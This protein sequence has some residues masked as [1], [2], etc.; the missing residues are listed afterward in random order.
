MFDVNNMNVL[1]TGA[2]RGIGLALAK[3]FKKAGANVWKIG[4]AHV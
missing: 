3:G 1:I 4:R 2:T